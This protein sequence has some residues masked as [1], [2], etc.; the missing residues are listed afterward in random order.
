[1]PDVASVPLHVA[2]SVVI[3]AAGVSRSVRSDHRRRRRPI[4]GMEPSGYRPRGVEAPQVASQSR[5]RLHGNVRLRARKVRAVARDCLRR[6]THI[7]GDGYWCAVPPVVAVAEPGVIV[8]E[9]KAAAAV[10]RAHARTTA[11]APPASSR[12]PPPLDPRGERE[13]GRARERQDQERQGSRGEPACA[14][15][16]G[17]RR[18][19]AEMREA[20]AGERRHR[21]VRPARRRVRTRRAPDGLLGWVVARC[22]GLSRSRA[23]VGA[24]AA[25]LTS[26][27]PSPPASGPGARRSRP[28][29]VFTGA[30]SGC[31]ACD[32]LGAASGLADCWAPAGTAATSEVVTTI[33]TQRKC[34]SPPIRPTGPLAEA[35]VLP[36]S[37]RCNRSP[38][39][40][41]G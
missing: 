37:R 33:V 32:A 15:G 4:D 30:G 9:T 11:P 17:R 7:E 36:G 14:A 2:V 12:H 29:G 21:D 25:G 27:S 34:V 10:G 16:V 8:L 38:T 40:S 24:A 1:M 5:F 39:H 22:T 3:E 13:Q 6:G 26:S 19:R 35:T 41:G 28:S 20:Q 31:G 23:G 18:G